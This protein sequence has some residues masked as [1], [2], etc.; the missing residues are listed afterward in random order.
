MR[1]I[2]LCAILLFS[3]G[4]G[5]GQSQPGH[6]VGRFLRADGLP[7]VFHL[8]ISGRGSAEIW[9]VRNAG[10]RIRITSIRRKGDSVTIDMPVFESAFRLRD[11]GHGFSGVW[12]KAGERQPDILQPVEIRPGSVTF[13]ADRGTASADITGRWK[14]AFTR[15]NGTQRAA[16]AEFRQT[17]QRLTGTFLTPTGDYRYLEGVVSGD[18]LQ[19]SCFD[20]SHAYYFGARLQGR[21]RILNGVFAA[22]LS[23]LEPWTAERDAE[24]S[25]DGASARMEWIPGSPTLRFR[26]P[27]L[28]SNIVSLDDE[29]Y[30]G[31]VV[32]LQIL[33]SWCPNCMDETAFLSEFYRKNRGRGIEVIGLAYEYSSDFQRSRRSLSKFRDRFGVE[34]P[35]LV[36]GV[37]SSD[38]LR[39]EK[40]L[41]GFTPIRAF[42]TTI[43]LGR[44]G[45]VRKTEAGYAGPATGRHHDEFRKEFEETIDALLRE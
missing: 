29:R 43:F 1:N 35:M 28:D 8:E 25:L 39:T 45:R 6:Y 7:I 3:G 21:D 38:T 44:D 2:L 16:I 14:V 20:G 36:T 19:L 42:P 13:P 40:T 37:T 15:P 22:G 23:H 30:R 32:V 12:V 33:G 31:K 27:D 11:H 26:F 18:S 10:E 9:T 17:G 4:S 34:Y 24:A 5:I 41:P